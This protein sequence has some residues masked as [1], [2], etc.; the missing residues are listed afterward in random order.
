MIS[1]EKML[2][3]MAWANAEILSQ[4]ATLEDE[5]LSAYAVNP[6]WT[7]REIIQHL[8]RSA[9]FYG[10]RLQIRS[11]A[12]IQ[13][14]ENDRNDY[15]QNEKAPV[16]SSEISKMVESLQAADAVLLGE[17]QLDDGTVYR[18]VE[19]K[20]IERARSTIIFQAIH[21]ATEHRAQLVS[22]LEA[23]GYSSIS[24]DEFDLWAYADKFGE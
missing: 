3:H 10:Y 17:A 4:V 22:A 21:H 16:C 15:I 9:H 5:A 12:D 19:G 14:G 24:L 6:E 7:V 13:S 11:P 18:E 1:S 8:V 2:K 20:L 23:R